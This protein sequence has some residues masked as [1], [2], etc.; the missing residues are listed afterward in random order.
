MRGIRGR[1]TSPER[2]LRSL[3]FA[4]GF[5]YRLHR[6]DL[7]GRPDLVLTRYRAVVFVHGC[8]WHRHDG[9]PM[10]TVPATNAKFWAEKF[11]A[12]VERD[13]RVREHLLN[14]GWRVATVWECA[15]SATNAERTARQLARWLQRQ[16][17]S[18]ELPAPPASS[19]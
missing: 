8:F 12:N 13:H 11:R 5:R 15:L 10:T 19:E 14:A 18:C 9:C 2:V 6:R 16:V 3:L 4:R 17:R 1:D 7:P